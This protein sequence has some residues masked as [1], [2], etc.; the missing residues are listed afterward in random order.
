MSFVILAILCAVFGFL[1]SHLY[2]KIA[3]SKSNG[4]NKE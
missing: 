2:F 1:G 4:G 3:E